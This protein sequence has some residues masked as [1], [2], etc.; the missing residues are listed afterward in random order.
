M[1]G[2]PGA[3]ADVQLARH[4]HPYPK[5]HPLYAET[6]DEQL[7]NT[8]NVSREDALRCYRDLLG[9]TGA[10]FA[11]VGDFDPDEL[12]KLMEQLFGDWKSPYPYARVVARHFD[13]P[14][15]ERRLPAPDK[16]NAALRAGLNIEMRS[17]HPDY[18]ALLLA[19]FLLGGSATARIPARV[20]EKDGLS[21]SAYSSF[22][23]SAL[24]PVASFR[25]SAIF[26]P[27]NRARVERAI[28]EELER[29]VREGFPAAEVKAGKSGLL[30]AR[31]LARTR[32]AALAGR[33]ANYLFLQ[34]T[35][36]WEETLEK[37]IASLSAEEVH[38]ALRRYLDP[39]M[40]SVMA[41]G[42]FK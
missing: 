22:W 2:D 17:D 20:R 3:I 34:R 5:G 16:A 7:Q 33:L 39:A 11:A 31:Q 36:A 26:A 40:L 41:A 13:R 37:R 38:A 35:F 8:R 18:P 23:A 12:V 4:L 42:D 24:D 6:I 32:D 1:R 30:K 10:E 27:Q 15:R 25:I 28:H 14:A 19:D 21:Y 29:A 9:A